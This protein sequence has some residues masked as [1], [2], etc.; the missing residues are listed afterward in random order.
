MKRNDWLIAGI[1]AVLF[2]FTL[3]GVM[4]F[5]LQSQ[6]YANLPE[7]VVSGTTTQNNAGAGL[8]TKDAFVAANVLANQWQPDARII[9]A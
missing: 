1:L 8:T 3:G 5:W 4:V 6:A 2:L 7:D 9:S